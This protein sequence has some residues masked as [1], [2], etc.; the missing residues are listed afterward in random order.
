MTVAELQALLADQPADREV[1][2]ESS[3]RVCLSD[4]NSDTD[5]LEGHSIYSGYTMD[6]TDEDKGQIVFLLQMHRDEDHTE[7]WSA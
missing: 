7:R 3:V 1:G 6:F 4:P 2:I 5:G